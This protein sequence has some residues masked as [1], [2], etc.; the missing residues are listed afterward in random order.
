[1]SRCRTYAA[2]PTPVIS[3]VVLT[4]SQVFNPSV[5]G[6]AGCISAAM[7]DGS[8]LDTEGR[9]IRPPTSRFVEIAEAAVP[10]SGFL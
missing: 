7:A 8:S 3:A 9:R 1:M 4:V 6:P 10:N 5:V 2:P